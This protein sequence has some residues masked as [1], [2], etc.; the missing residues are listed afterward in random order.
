[1]PSQLATKAI[2][3]LSPTIGEFLARA[4]VQAACN[5]AGLNIET[6]DKTQLDPFL[7][8]F[9]AVCVFDLGANVSQSLATRLRE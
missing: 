6:L 7:E 4:K 5:M 2:K 3:L 9:M 1:M 8:K